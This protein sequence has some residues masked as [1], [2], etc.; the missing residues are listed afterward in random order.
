[1]QSSVILRNIIALHNR[2]AYQMAITARIRTATATAT[3]LVVTTPATT[4]MTVFFPAIKKIN[5]GLCNVHIMVNKFMCN[6]EHNYQ[7]SFMHRCTNWPLSD[8]RFIC[9]VAN[10]PRPMLF[11]AATLNR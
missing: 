3:K 11:M 1:M 7:Y 5:I 9:T 10:G 8:S 2:L 6:Q 4:A